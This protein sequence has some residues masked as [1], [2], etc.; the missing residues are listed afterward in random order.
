MCYSRLKG[1][2][3]CK[4]KSNIMG[5]ENLKGFDQKNLT[6][7]LDFMGHMCKTPT[8]FEER[9]K[10]HIPSNTRFVL[11]LESKEE[12]KLSGTLRLMEALKPDI[13][14]HFSHENAVFNSQRHD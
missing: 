1:K 2:I 6:A 12:K 9:I 8:E 4:L 13:V 10:K 3:I 5:T 14:I 7:Q 11:E